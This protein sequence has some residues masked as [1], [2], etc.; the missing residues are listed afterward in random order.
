MPNILV[1]GAASGI[2]KAFVLHYLQNPEN[3]IFAIDKSFHD[4]GIPGLASASEETYEAY[5]KSV[6]CESRERLL[7]YTLDITNADQ[8]FGQLYNVQDLDLVIH[9]AGVRGLEP[10]I[11]ITQSS[12]VASAETIDVT[13]A[14]TMLSTFNTNAIGTFLLL[15]AL[16]PK[17]RSS[18][19]NLPKPK[20]I[21][22]GSR[23]GSI[24]HNTNGGGYAYR[25]S[26]AALN[27]IVKSFAV[28][29]PEAVWLIVHP[30]RVESGLVAVREEGAIG[31]EESVEDMVELIERFPEGSGKNG[32]F[33]DRFGGEIVW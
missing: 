4:P 7:L 26:K 3:H 13:S 5:H 24:G 14:S 18:S 22:M 31:A 6:N 11:P 10:S 1:A 12:D 33:V 16:I 27:A 32:S 15:R 23:M 2:G 8:V 9:S 19:S 21:I 17:F 25:A 28:D 30:G 20:V 29:V